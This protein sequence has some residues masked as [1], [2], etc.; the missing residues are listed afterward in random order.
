MTRS[1]ILTSPPP[2]A[3]GTRLLEWA[4]RD[5]RALAR[6]HARNFFYSFLV[7]PRRQ[8]QSMYALYA[9]MRQTDD[10]G[11][12]HEPTEIRRQALA[13][14]RRELHAALAGAR[15]PDRWWLALAD[16]VRRHDIPPAIL[17]GAISGVESD[18][19]TVR[20]ATF[21]ELYSYCYQVA[22]TVGLGCVRVWGVH[23]PRADLLAE[24]CGV[25]FQLTNVLRDVAED[26]RLGRIYLPADELARFEVGDL[27]RLDPARPGEA[28]DRLMRFQIARAHAYY[29]R[30]EELRDFLPPAGRAILRSMTDIYRGLLRRIERC[31][32]DVLRGRIRLRRARKFLLAARAFTTRFRPAGGATGGEPDRPVSAMEL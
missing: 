18:L 10:L 24:W 27:A 32:A 8:R 17:D 28:F 6:R 2:R 7:L 19:D 14:W 11:D 9:F 1:A 12:N 4:Y 5:C 26:L 13:Q 29:E 22:A 20:Y 16:T 15:L 21:A 3:E 25:A 23:H 31:P 30:A